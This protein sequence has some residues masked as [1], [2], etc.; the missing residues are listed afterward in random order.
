MQYLLMIH[1][2]EKAMQSVPKDDLAASR[3]RPPL[4]VQAT[5]SNRLIGSYLA[6]E[7]AIC[8][9]VAPGRTHRTTADDLRLCPRLDAPGVRVWLARQGSIRLTRQLDHISTHRRRDV[10]GPAQPRAEY[11]PLAAVRN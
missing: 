10:S 4:M 6:Q 3:E 2:D 7:W 11:G 9:I 1:S 8:H 5:T